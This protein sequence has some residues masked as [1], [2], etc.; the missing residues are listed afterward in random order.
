MGNLVLL[1]HRIHKKL[2]KLL[3]RNSL[4]MTSTIE[5]NISRK[6]TRK[7]IPLRL[8]VNRGLLVIFQVAEYCHQ[9]A[10]EASRLN[11][12]GQDEELLVNAGIRCINVFLQ[13]TWASKD[14]E[15]YSIRG[16][17]FMMKA[18]I[19]SD[20]QLLNK[21]R[22]DFQQAINLGSTD[23]LKTEKWRNNIEQ[24]E[25]ISKTLPGA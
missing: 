12:L 8:V 22:E 17:L 18:Q 3:L 7:I 9:V 10:I 24:I 20:P 13:E 21:A 23:P 16:D 6:R 1:L 25:I 19:K 14:G 11:V 4:G 15:P 2:E 5:M